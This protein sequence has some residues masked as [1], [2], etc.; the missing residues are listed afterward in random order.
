MG[1]IHVISAS[2]SKPNPGMAS[3]DLAFHALAARHGFA[4]RVTFWQLGAAP[5]L[6]GGKRPREQAEIASREALPFHY[7]DAWGRL[8]EICAG[9]VIVFWGDFLHMAHYQRD[10]GE[11]LARLELVPT[12]AAGCRSARQLF[13]L[14]EAPEDVLAKSVSYGTNLLFNQAAD[15]HDPEYG[16]LL[17]R[18]VRGVDRIWMRDPYSAM[19]VSRLRQEFTP[20]HLGFDCSLFLRDGDLRG[21]PRQ[22]TLDES[23]GRGKAGLFFHRSSLSESALCG[24]ALELCGELGVTAQWL[25]WRMPTHQGRARLGWRNYGRIEQIADAASPQLGDL[26]ELLS[27]Y[28]LVVTDTYHVCVTAWRLGVPAVCLGEADP[29]RDWDVSAGPAFA[30]RDKRLVFHAM[31]DAQDFF[32]HAGEIGTWRWRRRRVRQLAELLQR[33]EIAAGVRERVLAQRD[34]VEQDLVAAIRRLEGGG[35][36]HGRARTVTDRQG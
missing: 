11:R 2:V 32:V 30:W 17:R 22:W 1:A 35:G 20:D 12:A 34:T 26:Y 6:R 5:E 10:I 28:R 14:S 33:P 31:Y 8:D 27:R 3:V 23:L 24:F 13:L 9:A 15:Y 19:T 4:D 7:A 36:E 25:P 16:P 18:L 29:R 21:L